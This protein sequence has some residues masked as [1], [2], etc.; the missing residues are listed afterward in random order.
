MLRY[1]TDGS[2]LYVDLLGTLI[3]PEEPEGD[4]EYYVIYRD[5]SERKRAEAE[6]R[7][8]LGRLEKAWEQTIQILASV[9]ELRDPYTAGHQRRVAVLAQ[10]VARELGLSEAE[11]RGVYLASLV[12]DVGKITVPAEVLSKPGVLSSVEFALI[13]TH[14]G[15]GYDILRNIDFPWPVAEIVLQHHERLDGSGYPTDFPERPSGRKHAFSPWRTWW[16]PWR[17][18]V[19]T[20]LPAV[21]KKP[22][23]K[24]TRARANATT[25]VS[26]HP[27]GIYSG[28]VSPFPLFPSSSSD[29]PFRVESVFGNSRRFLS[30]HRKRRF[31]VGAHELLPVHVVRQE[32]RAGGVRIEPVTPKPLEHLIPFVHVRGGH[33]AVQR[34]APQ[35]PIDQGGHLVA[36]QDGDALL[37]EFDEEEI[38]QAA[39]LIDDLLPFCG[40][41]VG[42]RQ[43]NFAPAALAGIFR[44]RTKRSES[45]SMWRSSSYLRISNSARGLYRALQISKPRSSSM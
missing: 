37:V 14:A 38:G 2:P 6:L 7:E 45:G 8:S 29:R 40:H 36:V 15:A 11:V 22:L 4:L 43:K 5:I 25:P 12:H 20:V 23:R 1:R 30:L 24:S 26:W 27:A 34:D 17:R 31:V 42:L 16:R 32:I 10:A 3:L 13:R 44:F 28:R 19:P 39:E 18:T 41:F 35:F 33:I 21:S 9:V